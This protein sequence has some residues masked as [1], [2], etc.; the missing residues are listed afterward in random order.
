MLA[1]LSK[2]AIRLQ[3]YRKLSYFLGFIL[4]V[5]IISRLFQKPLLNQV[6]SPYAIL[7]FVGCIWLILFNLLLSLFDNV[8]CINDNVDG[9]ITRFKIR[10]QR[11]IYHFLSII[12]V[13]LTTVI[14]WLSFRLLRI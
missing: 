11:G 5:F 6:S 13:G 4:I 10:I 8:P 9:V 1:L 7:S 14:L 12:F 3:P 2:M